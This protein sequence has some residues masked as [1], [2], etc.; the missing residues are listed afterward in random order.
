MF[1]EQ[2][3]DGNIL[4]SMSREDIATKR[5]MCSCIFLLYRADSIP[6]SIS[7]NEVKVSEQGWPG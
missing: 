6:H 1:A 3:I 2:Q 7:D 4:A 5:Y